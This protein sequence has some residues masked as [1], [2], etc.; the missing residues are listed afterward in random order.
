MTQSPSNE[1]FPLPLFHIWMNEARQSEPSDPDA[2]CL[3][4]VDKDGLPNARVVLIRKIDERGFCFFTNTE[5]QK[6]LELNSSPKAAI[7]FHWKTLKRQV[8]IRGHIERVSEIESDEYY[9]SRPL[10][11][12]IGAWASLQSQKLESRETLI[13][14]VSEKEKELGTNPKRP[15]HWG[16]YRIIP[17]SIEFWQE[18]EHRL[19]KRIYYQISNN[20]TWQK[21]ELYP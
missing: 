19:H 1:S 2:A 16:G 21:S 13:S 9:Q 20:G 12:R 10:G 14:R 7:N 8:R 15:P 17:T 5:S 6:G 18:G 11:N 3:A 4:T